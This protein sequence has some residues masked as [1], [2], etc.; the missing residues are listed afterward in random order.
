MWA[1][2]DQKYLHS[3]AAQQA[4]AGFDFPVVLVDNLTGDG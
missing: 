4:F 2:G 3:G 1:A